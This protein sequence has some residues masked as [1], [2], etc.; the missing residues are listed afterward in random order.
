[1]G[2]CKKNAEQLPNLAIQNQ[3]LEGMIN[4]MKEKIEEYAKN[5]DELLIDWG[6]LVKL[7][8]EGIV[9]L[10]GEYKEN[11]ELLSHL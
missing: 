9:D 8:Q 10:D 4:K 5:Q 1:M 7:Y 3:Y 2:E 11:H 6:K